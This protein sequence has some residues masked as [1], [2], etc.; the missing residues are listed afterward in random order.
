[1]DKDV[2]VIGDASL[3]EEQKSDVVTLVEGDAENALPKH[4]RLNDDGTVT[5]PLFVP[6]TI[7]YTSSVGGQVKEDTFTEFTMRR[8][9]G[10]DMEIIQGAGG[11]QAANVAVAISAGISRPLF[12]VLAKKMDGAD[13]QAAGDVVIYFLKNGP[14]TGRSS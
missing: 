6:Q 13:L 2:L 8:F 12:K 9:N 14:R 11:A 4:A 5:L 10:G 1:M 7:K 3:L